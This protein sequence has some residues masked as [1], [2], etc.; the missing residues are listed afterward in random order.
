MNMIGVKHTYLFILILY[1]ISCCDIL[2]CRPPVIIMCYFIK[3]FECLTGVLLIKASLKIR[4][5]TNLLPLRKM[6]Y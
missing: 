2:L 4:V 3:I 6:Y 5:L 1:K